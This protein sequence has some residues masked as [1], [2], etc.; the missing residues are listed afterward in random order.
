MHTVRDTPVLG[1]IYCDCRWFH[2]ASRER[3]FGIHTGHNTAD[4]VR[5]LV[6]NRVIGFKKINFWTYE[7]IMKLKDSQLEIR[8]VEGI[9]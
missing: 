1:N 6:A 9:L 4:N 7:K 3:S 2:P 5:S 8:E